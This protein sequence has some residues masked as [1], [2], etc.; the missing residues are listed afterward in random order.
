MT[1]AEDLRVRI[2]AMQPK[3]SSTRRTFTLRFLMIGIA[4]AT[5]PMAMLH[6]YL[7]GPVWARRVVATVVFLGS[8]VLV[9]GLPLALL[10]GPYHGHRPGRSALILF[11]L[12]LMICLL[13]TLVGGML[14]TPAAQ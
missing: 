3:E 8:L 2:D 12:F 4:L 7:D 10:L 11:L 13:A 14:E 5:V 1:T 6:Y 9:L